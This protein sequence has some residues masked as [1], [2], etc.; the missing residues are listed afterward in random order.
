V[1]IAFLDFSPISMGLTA[2][3]SV[4]AQPFDWGPG[5]WGMHYM[6]GAWGVGMMLFM[7]IFWLL[8]IA[9]VIALL[10]WLW[11]AG[12]GAPR[13]A[14]DAAEDI[15]KKRYAR[16]EISKEEFQSTLQELRES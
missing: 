7:L 13:S 2:A 11:S 15:L 4:A 10:R 5:G 8:V 1:R 14:G 16:G 9:G 6:W 12:G 3:S